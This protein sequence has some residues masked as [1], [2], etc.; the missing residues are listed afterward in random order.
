[1]E[2]V[3]QLGVQAGVAPLCA[4]LGVPRAT[5]YRHQHP[6]EEQAVR[7]TPARALPPEERQAVL[8]VL[9][10]ERFIDKAPPEVWST[11]LGEGTYLC[12]PRTMY[13]I[14]A[15][16]EEVR[17]R[18]NQRRHPLYKKPELVA[19][20]PNEV[21]SW[22]I[23]KLKG[24]AKFV[25][26]YLYVILD[27]YSRYAVAWMVAENENAKLSG[28]LIRAAYEKQGVEPDSL[29][30]HSDRGAP[31]TAHTT[32]QLLASLGVE[33]SHSRPHVSN[34]NP[35]SESGFKTLKYNPK[36]PERFGCIEDAL[37]FCRTFFPWYNNEHAHS[38]LLY[39]TPAQ[40]HYGVAD[41]VLRQRHAVLL[42]AYE[43]NPERFICGPPERKHLPPAV[44]I[45][46][47]DPRSATADDDSSAGVPVAG[48]QVDGPPGEEAGGKLASR[49]SLTDCRGVGGCHPKGRSEAKEARSALTADETTATPSATP[50]QQNDTRDP[51]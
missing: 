43:Q 51:P 23:T 42:Q 45:N 13:R 15:A 39:L 29:V 31:M 47:P 17:E 34:D 8:D 44:W 2:A 5:F 7:P 33:R 26:Y 12:S 46:P 49:P 37:S 9:H 32:A 16:E 25:Y 1:M 18:R 24:P 38:G 4:A 14:L 35:F 50:T 19:R 28:R 27:I 10:S 21:W 22:D 3:K 20:R 6:K 36:F 30:L 41:V 40:V 48:Q 11:L